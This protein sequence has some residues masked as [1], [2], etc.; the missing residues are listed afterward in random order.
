MKNNISDTTVENLR[1]IIYDFDGVMTDNK[2]YID[3]DGREMV[4]VN[5]SDGLGVAAIKKLG[6]EQLIIS[7]EENPVVSAR[8]K[9]LDIPCLQGIGDKKIA[10]INYCQDNNINFQK[11]AYVGNDIN[12]KEAM[13][14]TGVT[15]CPSDAHNR[16]KEMTDHTL[17]AK[18]GDGVVRELL[19]FIIELRG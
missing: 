4:Q 12:D 14:I 11:V 2:V 10:I 8:A 5:R 16:I 3:Q 18:G 1:L 13:E 9:K 15:F 17:K 7:T 19:D 6:I